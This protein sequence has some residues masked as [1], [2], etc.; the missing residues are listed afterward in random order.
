MK[1]TLI[2]E[3]YRDFPEAAIRE[4]TA[5]KETYNSIEIIELTF[6]YAVITSEGEEYKRL[7]YLREASLEIARAGSYLE[8]SKASLPDGKYFLRIKDAKGCH[9]TKD[10]PVLGDV[11]NSRGRVDFKSPDFVINAFHLNEWH[12]ARRSYLNSNS[13][14]DSRRAP[15]RPFFSPVSLHPK[16]ARLM[17]N[18]ARVKNGDVVFDPFCG[19]G[20]IL[21]EAGF[22]GM[23]VI[24]NDVS[25]QMYSGAR[26][27]LKYYHIRDAMFFNKDFVNLQPEFKADSIVT[28]LPYGRNSHLSASSVSKLYS[29][30]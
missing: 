22:M 17:V 5:I 15:L 30:A 25:L 29:A 14:L 8:F 27:N 26:L 11:L 9:G 23:R 19:T 7:T 6:P 3:F 20:G 13:S 2:L 12:L 21:I 18:L 24:G 28:D 10:E 1:N 16:I 4:L